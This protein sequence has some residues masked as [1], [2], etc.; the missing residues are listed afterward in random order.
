[1]TWICDFGVVNC[2]VCQRAKE[3]IKAMVPDIPDK[4]IDKALRE[5]KIDLHRE[6]IEAVSIE[7]MAGGEP[8][9]EITSKPLN[10][11]AKPKGIKTDKD[12]NPKIG[13]DNPNNPFFTRNKQPINETNPNPWKL[14]DIYFAGDSV[15][16]LED[17]T[18]TTSIKEGDYPPMST[19]SLWSIVTGPMYLEPSLPS[20]ETELGPLLPSDYRTIGRPIEAKKNEPKKLVPT[21]KLYKDLKN[22][23]ETEFYKNQG[24]RSYKARDGKNTIIVDRKSEIQFQ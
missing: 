3:T 10:K 2:P 20:F 7:I 13:I 23:D 4:I 16:G 21:S 19:P 8:K 12:R 17:F 11:E 9:I 1:M 6:K 14:D 18:W 22:N 24:I 15:I 5:Q